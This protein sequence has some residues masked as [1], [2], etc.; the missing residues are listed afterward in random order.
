MG[1]QSRRDGGRERER[2]V[3]RRNDRKTKDSDAVVIVCVA[4]ARVGC[5]V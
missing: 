5:N 3:G 2:E 4:K 1:H